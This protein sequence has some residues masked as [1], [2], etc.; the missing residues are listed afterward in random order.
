M[1]LAAMRLL[2]EPDPPSGF[3]LRGGEIHRQREE[4]IH[5]VDVLEVRKFDATHIRLSDAALLPVLDADCARDVLDAGKNEGAGP[6]VVE[7]EVAD[8]CCALAADGF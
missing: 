8:D 7:A 5:L 2:S 1:R 4:E 3:Q 6:G